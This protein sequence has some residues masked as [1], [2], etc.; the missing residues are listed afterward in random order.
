MDDCPR[1]VNYER[2]IKAPDAEDIQYKQQ[3]L[4]LVARTHCIF[5]DNASEC[6]RSG[7]VRLRLEYAEPV[8]SPGSAMRQQM[9]IT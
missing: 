4:G 2:M 6:P 7:I 3:M 9:R 8:K 5:T 1:R